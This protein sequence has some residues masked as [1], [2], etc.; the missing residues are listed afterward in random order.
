VSSRESA[1]AAPDHR[2]RLVH[3]APRTGPRRAR[4]RRRGRTRGRCP[5]P[6]AGVRVRRTGRPAQLAA[7]RRRP[8]PHI[9]AACHVAGARGRRD[10]AHRLQ[11]RQRLRA[12]GV[13]RRQRRRGS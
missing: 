13:R 12:R 11:G 5:A 2:Q 10:R 7:P 4:R 8:A 6:D 1:P 9:R 3:R